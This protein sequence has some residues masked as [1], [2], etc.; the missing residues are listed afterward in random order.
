MKKGMDKY[1]KKRKRKSSKIVKSLPIISILLIIASTI[2]V[3]T[4]FKEDFKKIENEISRALNPNLK[5]IEDVS[6]YAKQN[7]Q[8][9]GILPSIT[10]AQAILESDFGRSALSKEYN[11][12]FGIKSINKDEKRVTFST[13]E[14]V[15]NN[16]IEIKDAFKVFDSMED[17]VKYHGLLIGTAKIY[18]KVVEAKDYVEAA[19]MLYECGYATDPA[20]A[21]KLIEIIEQY[22]LYEYD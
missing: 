3:S 20:Y 9:Y 22:K 8:E 21:Q 2:I 12:Y 4:L 10:I 18:Q 1:P 14:Y 6:V 13:K 11:N 5:F 19:N 16:Q 17:S 15:N 7:Y